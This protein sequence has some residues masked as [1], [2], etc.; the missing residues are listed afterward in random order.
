MYLIVYFISSQSQFENKYPQDKTAKGSQKQK[1]LCWNNEKDHV[2]LLSQNFLECDTD[3]TI[4]KANPPK[5][6]PS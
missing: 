4:E 5:K 3:F 6:K 2:Y 1:Q